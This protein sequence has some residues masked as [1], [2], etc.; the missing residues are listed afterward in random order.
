MEKH[1]VWGMPPD[2]PSIGAQDVHIWLADL[3][4]QGSDTTQW[5]DSLAPDEQARAARFYFERDRRRFVVGRAVL[6]SIL[7]RYLGIGPSR[8][9]F[10]YGP[11][12]KPMLA[13]CCGDAALR[14]N[15][16]HS[17]GLALVAVTRS[18]EVGVDLERIRPLADMQ[19]IAERCFSSQESAMLQ[20]LPSDR[21]SEGFFS[22]WTRKEAFLKALGDGL[23]RPLDTFAVSFL[24]G[25][26]AKLVWVSGE[27]GDTSRWSLWGLTPAPETV[28]AVVVE[29][30]GER[31]TC[32]QW[33]A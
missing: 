23:A 3:D 12:G 18:S 4:L 27:A 9:A 16:S 1:P 2:R 22:C 8:L 7:G 33:V 31:L 10:S 19:Q 21:R 30:K 28:G 17:H 25:E 29:A 20:S 5:M 11:H 24:P 26:P 6:R 15:L 13:G 14:F 32:W